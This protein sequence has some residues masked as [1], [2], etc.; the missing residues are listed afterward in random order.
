MGIGL[1]GLR[2]ALVGADSMGVSRDRTRR[3]MPVALG[4][5]SMRQIRSPG[6]SGKF[7]RFDDRCASFSLPVV[8]E[9]TFGCFGMSEH[10]LMCEPTSSSKQ[11]ASLGRFGNPLLWQAAAWQV[12]ELHSGAM[13]GMDVMVR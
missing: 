10:R 11:R 12:S 7:V 5:D 1:T 2:A 4:R 6:R 8:I 9:T 13:R 3:S